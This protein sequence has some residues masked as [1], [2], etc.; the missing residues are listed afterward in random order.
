[1]T[2]AHA[3]LSRFREIKGGLSRNK[4]FVSSVPCAYCRG[5]G[6][7]PAYGNTSRCPVCGA[8]GKIAVTSPVVSCLKCIGTGRERGK[9][10]CLTC[11][12]IGVASVGKDATTCAKC[13]GTGK[14]GVFNCTP[15]K[16]QGIV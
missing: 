14:D 6:V 4:L 11:R 10:S 16:G 2:Y 1:M 3:V 5:S 8:S 7:D 13:L 12:G 9:L 15:C